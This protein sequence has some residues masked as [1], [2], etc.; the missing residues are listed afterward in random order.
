LD[1]LVVLAKVVD[2]LTP[3]GGGRLKGPQ[4]EAYRFNLGPLVLDGG[5]VEEALLHR[6]KERRDVRHA[7]SQ[8]AQ[9][10]SS[11][12]VHQVKH[13]RDLG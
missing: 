12:L 8:D 13:V 7:L 10:L 3:L 11:P 5:L 1:A 9:R 4:Q 2:G 6:H